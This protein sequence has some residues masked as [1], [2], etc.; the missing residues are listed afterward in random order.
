MKQSTTS[1][2]PFAQITQEILHDSF[3][4]KR[5]T[6]TLIGTDWDDYFETDFGQNLC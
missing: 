5:E 2:F 1:T 4:P 6:E 3:S